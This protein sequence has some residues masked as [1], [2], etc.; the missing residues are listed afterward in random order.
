MLVVAAGPV[1][2]QDFPDG[3]RPMA[4]YPETLQ[5]AWTRYSAVEREMLA[6]LLSLR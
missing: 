5:P 2:C 1:L 3:E 4:Y 6:I